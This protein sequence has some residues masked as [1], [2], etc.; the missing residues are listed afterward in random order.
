MGGVVFAT[1]DGGRH[2][3]AKADLEHRFVNG[4]FNAMPGVN[5]GKRLASSQGNLPDMSMTGMPSGAARTRLMR[6]SPVNR[7]IL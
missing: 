1:S 2:W 6:S 3:K 5:N 7:G 4:F